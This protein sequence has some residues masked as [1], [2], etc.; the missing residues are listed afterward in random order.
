MEVSVAI[1][2]KVGRLFL[3]ASLRNT[4]VITPPGF[5]VHS[6]IIE[7][8]PDPRKTAGVIDECLQFLSTHDKH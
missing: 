4:H 1:E 6:K 8:F 5:Q 3:G 7:Q 2:L